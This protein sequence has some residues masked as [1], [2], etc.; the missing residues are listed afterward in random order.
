MKET[1]SCKKRS[2]EKCEFQPVR[3][4]REEWVGGPVRFFTDKT[5]EGYIASFF[6]ARN[7][8]DRARIRVCV[9]KGCDEI[10]FPY[11]RDL[12]DVSED[13]FERMAIKWWNELDKYSK[14]KWS[15]I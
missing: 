5:K 8:R 11:A 14:H 7:E 6:E 9:P 3:H 10:V 4:K 13:E 1:L 15:L 12:K 2:K